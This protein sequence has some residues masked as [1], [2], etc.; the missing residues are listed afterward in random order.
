MQVI[1]TQRQ[2]EL[3]MMLLWKPN[4]RQQWKHAFLKE[5]YRTASEKGACNLQKKTYFLQEKC[6]SGAT[7]W[8]LC[9]EQYYISGSLDSNEILQKQR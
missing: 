9:G 6:I 7:F 8:D 5:H 2:Y 3:S 4:T 1:K